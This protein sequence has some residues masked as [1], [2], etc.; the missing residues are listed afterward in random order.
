MYW[1]Q[2]YELFYSRVA[3]GPLQGIRYFSF[4]I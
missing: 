3:V 1:R 4:L 2:D